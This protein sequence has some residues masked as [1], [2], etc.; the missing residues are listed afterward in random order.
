[1]D[2]EVRRKFKTNNGKT[3]R[4]CHVV[5]GDEDIL[6]AL[7]SEWKGVQQQLSWKIEP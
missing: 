1:M 6:N 3:I 5:S 7:E 2:I 4:W